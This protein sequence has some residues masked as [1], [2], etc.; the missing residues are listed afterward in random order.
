MTCEF[1][2]CFC[3]TFANNIHVIC[4]Y[5]LLNIYMNI[6]VLLKQKLRSVYNIPAHDS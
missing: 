3:I 5:I 4:I 1:Y 2:N 6:Y